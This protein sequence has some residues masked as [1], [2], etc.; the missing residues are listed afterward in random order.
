MFEIFKSI[1]TYNR[2]FWN[3]PSKVYLAFILDLTLAG[4]DLNDSEAALGKRSPVVECDLVHIQKIQDYQ[5]VLIYRVTLTAALVSLASMM[6][7]HTWL[8]LTVDDG[9]NRT[10]QNQPGQ[11]LQGL[12]QHRCLPLHHWIGLKSD[13]FQVLRIRMLSRGS[14]GMGKCL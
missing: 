7:L 11:K 1:W 10:D 4:L 12:R 5:L 6:L 8:E 2:P 9:K 13:L 3:T 14:T